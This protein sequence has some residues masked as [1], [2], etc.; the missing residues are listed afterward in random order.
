MGISGH[1]LT[2]A[3][4]FGATLV[5][6]R[7]LSLSLGVITGS[8]LLDADHIVDY[9]LIDKQRSLNPVRFLTFYA[10]CFPLRRLILLHSYELLAVL[11]GLAFMTGSK[12]LAGFVAGSLIH[13]GTDILPRGSLPPWP[14]I[15]LYSFIYR[16]HHGFNSSRL[17][18]HSLVPD[19]SIVASRLRST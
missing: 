8:L 1:I 6:T 18:Q 16:W 7:S 19:P 15:K 11:L 10:K 9:L 4:A 3:A 17:Y 5:V 12:A 13:L 14:R 2:S